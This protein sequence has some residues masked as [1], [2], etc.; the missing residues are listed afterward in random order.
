M[1]RYTNWSLILF[2]GILVVLALTSRTWIPE[3]QPSLVDEPE[4]EQFGCPGFV[5]DEQCRNLREI[6]ELDPVLAEHLRDSLDPDND[7]ETL[8]EPEIL[9]V[10]RNLNAN[11]SDEPII[12]RVKTGSFNDLD[13]I[14]TASGI[15]DINEIVFPSDSTEAWRFLTLDE[16]FEVISGPDFQVYLSTLQSPRNTSDLMDSDPY[17]VGFLKGN[18]GRQHLEL[19]TEVDLTQY[20]SVVIYSE[21]YDIIAAIAP[22]VTN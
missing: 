12:T 4:A 17:Q 9:E 6:N 19:D 7:L 5:S 2:C 15:V 22:I 11:T 21:E 10:A 20:R 14:R 13:V 8:D 18:I 16:D 1:R 3:V